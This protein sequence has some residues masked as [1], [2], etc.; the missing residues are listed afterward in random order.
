MKCHFLLQKMS[1][2]LFKW[3]PRCPLISVSILFFFK[4]PSS[5]S[6]QHQS[7]DVILTVQKWARILG[8]SLMVPD[9][10]LMVF[11]V[12][13]HLGLICVLKIPCKDSLL[14]EEC[15]THKDDFMTF[16]GAGSLWEWP[17][18]ICCLNQMSRWLYRLHW[19][20]S[21]LRETV[22]KLGVLVKTWTY[23]RD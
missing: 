17:F 18:L 19:Y 3:P 7:G 16:F 22:R 12:T 21:E 15:K 2:K 8:W 23:F 5:W 14:Y 4:G 9:L 13:D 6:G 1:T 11:N 20:L 10:D